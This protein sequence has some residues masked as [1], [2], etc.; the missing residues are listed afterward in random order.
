MY[1]IFVNIKYMS[2]INVN[3]RLDQEIKENASYLAE[4]MW[5]NLSTIINVFL[6]KFTNE[7]KFEFSLPEVEFENFWKN[8]VKDIEN[9]SNFNSFISSVKWK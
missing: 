5:T 4:K 2:K 7:K 6:V 3:I 1:I 9:L 8:E